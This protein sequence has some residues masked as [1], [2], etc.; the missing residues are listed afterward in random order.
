[1]LTTILG[2]VYRLPEYASLFL[3]SGA[4]NKR[5]NAKYYQI[6]PKSSLQSLLSNVIKNFDGAFYF[7]KHVSHLLSMKEQDL[8]L[9]ALYHL[10]Y[11]V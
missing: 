4:L 2:V 8:L 5:I 1:M 10:Q 3:L 9:T 6:A 11:N 7:K